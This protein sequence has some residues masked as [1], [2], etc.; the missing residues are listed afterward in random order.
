MNPFDVGIAALALLA[1]VALLVRWPFYRAIV[2]ESLLHPRSEGWVEWVNDRVEVHR[3]I[4]LH[5]YV[6]REAITELHK[7]QDALAA[8]A[9][10]IQSSPLPTP[11]QPSS[12]W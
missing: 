3:G 8:G 9:R 6:L 11:G 7:T 5:N 10:E 1:V 4:S 2:F 12:S